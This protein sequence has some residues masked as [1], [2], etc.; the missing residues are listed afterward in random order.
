MGWPLRGRTFSEEDLGVDFT[1]H[2]E[3]GAEVSQLLLVGKFFIEQEID[4]GFGLLIS[5]LRDG[6]T[7][8]VETLCGSTLEVVQ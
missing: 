2:L 6:L 5:E 7:D 4:N 3:V 8:V 1:A